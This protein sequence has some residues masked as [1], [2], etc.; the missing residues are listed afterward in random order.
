MVKTMPDELKS[1]L[2]DM[3]KAVNSLKQTYATPT[4]LLI[5]AESDSEFE[6]LLLHSHVTWLSNGK[7]LKRVFVLQ[8][9]TRISA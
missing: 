1:V 5:Y 9:N 3:I 7:V 2:N 8:K 4:Y 6:T